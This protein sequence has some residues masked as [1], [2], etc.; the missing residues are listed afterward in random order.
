M[1]RTNGRIDRFLLK[2][3]AK[4]IARSLGIENFRASRS[5][6]RN[7][8]AKQETI[9][10]HP[11]QVTASTSRPV[12]DSLEDE[13]S[14][15]RDKEKKIR[16]WKKCLPRL[17]SRCN[18]ED[19]FNVD[20]V[21]IYYKMDLSRF[22]NLSDSRSP[23]RS[24]GKD[25]VTVLL[26]SNASGTEKLPLLI[27]AK[28]NN[29]CLQTNVLKWNKT[30]YMTSKLFREYMTRLNK[31]MMKQHRK[32]LV[33][34]DNNTPHHVMRRISLKN[35]TCVFFPT[36]TTAVLQ[37]IDLGIAQSFGK[38]YFQKVSEHVCS[39]LGTDDRLNVAD[40]PIDITDGVKWARTAW[41]EVKSSTI[42]NSFR[43][44]GFSVTVD[45]DSLTE[46][47]INSLRYSGFGNKKEGI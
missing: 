39:A 20:E 16:K 3:K 2:E 10:P 47:S 17:T 7:L 23:P 31:K 28:S 43:Q 46:M 22:Q 36:K 40:I 45:N 37:P 1:K 27:I 9:S 21:G 29:H 38:L 12:T 4:A 6:V 30:G 14:L 34:L 5:W 8:L 35:V 26:G 15:L 33:F 25:M 13:S 19:I 11:K 44:A 41:N 42:V 18:T 32:I 24:S